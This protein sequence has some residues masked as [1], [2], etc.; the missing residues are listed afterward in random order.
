MWHRYEI[1][2]RGE[3]RRARIVPPTSQNQARIE[4]DLRDSLVR[5]GLERPEHELRR[6]AEMV[7][8]NYDP[9][10][11]CA[12]HFLTL[13]IDRGD[14]TERAVPAAAA[15]RVRV[16]ALGTEQAGDDVALRLLERLRADAALA[17][18]I[19]DGRVLLHASRQPLLDWPQALRDDEHLF[20]IDAV[21]DAA[22]E[23]ALRLIDVAALADET[24]PLS[25]HDLGVAQARDLAAALGQDARRFT[26]LGIAVGA[27]GEMPPSA[28]WSR[29]VDEVRARLLACLGWEACE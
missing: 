13:H 15:Q 10:I 26:L 3:I 4:A 28:Q 16:L 22:A 12:T 17:P 9:C 25:G 23:G 18:Y 6:H 5:L 14:G 27:A 1:D 29:L 21:R 8:R 24:R 11:S 2:A 20:V 19:A 7:I